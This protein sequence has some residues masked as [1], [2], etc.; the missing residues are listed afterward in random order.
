MIA[1]RQPPGNPGTPAEPPQP[2]AA[3]E[4]PLL[5]D[6]AR[7]RQFWARLLGRHEALHV[8]AGSPLLL[9][10]AP[11]PP[12]RPRLVA[13]L[14]GTLTDAGLGEAM[15]AVLA[16]SLVPLIREIVRQQLGGD[17]GPQPAPARRPAAVDHLAEVAGYLDAAGAPLPL[18]PARPCDDPRKCGT[19]GTEESLCPPC[20]DVAVW[21]A[22]QRERL[23][24]R[25]RL[26]PALREFLALCKYF[27]DLM[28]EAIM[29]TIAEAVGALVAALAAERNAR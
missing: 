6:A 18:P 19:D 28:G 3:A 23:A 1:R 12:R 15:A 26:V 7:A 2:G 22:L 25:E 16:P 9:T 8:A 14:I 5:A 10:D 24:E 17:S 27:P 29:P 13:D 4:G 21:E 20:R 11:T